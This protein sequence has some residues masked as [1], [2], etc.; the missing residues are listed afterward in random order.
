MTKRKTH[1]YFNCLKAYREARRMIEEM[2]EWL[3]AKAKTPFRRVFSRG[4]VRGHREGRLLAYKGKRT[5]GE[6]LSLPHLKDTLRRRGVHGGLW[7][8]S[9][10]PLSELRIEDLEGKGEDVPYVKLT[11]RSERGGAF[12][13]EPEAR[14]GYPFGYSAVDR[15][16]LEG[17]GGSIRGCP[18]STT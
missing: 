1:G 18:S 2:M 11:A 8:L 5:G 6:V 3:E 13:V 9:L 15:G 4:P 17:S 14:P 7:G 10:L 16:D 12:S